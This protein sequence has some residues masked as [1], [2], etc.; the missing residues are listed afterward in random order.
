MTLLMLPKYQWSAIKSQV[1]APKESSP[2]K[3]C[4]IICL[5]FNEVPKVAMNTIK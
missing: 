2:A 5:F 3:T 1:N 4:L